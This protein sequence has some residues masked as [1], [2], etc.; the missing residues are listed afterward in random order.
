MGDADQNVP[1]SILSLLR[2]QQIRVPSMQPW[3]ERF[4]QAVSP[5]IHELRKVSDDVLEQY[6]HTERD[7]RRAKASQFEL[8][9]AAYVFPPILQPSTPYVLMY[10]ED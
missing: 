8:F 9:V 3:Y 4:P 2:G 7:L 10:G 6:I 1:I 5:Q